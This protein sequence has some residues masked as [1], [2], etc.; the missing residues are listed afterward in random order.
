LSQERVILTL[1]VIHFKSNVIGIKRLYRRKHLRQTSVVIKIQ[2][3][4]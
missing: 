2:R 1:S 3:N 4:C